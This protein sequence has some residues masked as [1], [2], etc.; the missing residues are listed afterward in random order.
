MATT[1]ESTRKAH[2]LHPPDGA[3]S[4]QGR[5][6][7]T[8]SIRFPFSFYFKSN[9]Q[10]KISDPKMQKGVLNFKWEWAQS[11]LFSPQNQNL[12]FPMYTLF[13]FNVKGDFFP[14]C[15]FLSVGNFW[16]NWERFL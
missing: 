8:P 1:V 15:F 5:L 11:S 13:G 12:V 7:S 14:V 2:D 9:F 4:Q 3:T 10:K 16:K 6:G